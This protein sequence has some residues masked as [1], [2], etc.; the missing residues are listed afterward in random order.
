MCAAR[1][2]DGCVAGLF[3]PCVLP[4]SR[5]LTRRGS[6]ENQAVTMH[7]RWCYLCS[8]S[9]AGSASSAAARSAM[10]ASRQLRQWLMCSKRP[11]GELPSDSLNSSSG[12][13]MRICRHSSL[14]LRKRMGCM[15]PELFMITHPVC[16]EVSQE[17]SVFAASLPVETG[18]AGQRFLFPRNRV[19]SVQSQVALRAAAIQS[20]CEDR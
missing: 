9:L 4:C 16:V 1:L 17:L 11:D 12:R 20:G 14:K 7:G 8:L 5:P 6:P 18:P 10:Y 15:V 13:F 19:A 2:H 3:R